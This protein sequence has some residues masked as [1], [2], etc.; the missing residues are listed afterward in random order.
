MRTGGSVKNLC[1]F[2]LLSLVAVTMPK[3]LCAQEM[4]PTQ[5]PSSNFNSIYLVL[6]DSYAAGS[7]I[8]SKGVPFWQLTDNDLS[9][10]Y[11]TITWDHL[12]LSGVGPESWPDVLPKL[13]SD[14]KKKG[15]CVGYILFQT[16]SNCFFRPNS[17]DC[18]DCCL[19]AT[20]SQAVSYSY[21]YKKYLST[22]IG[23]IY[24]A[25]P[26]VKLVV[27]TVPDPWNGSGKFASTSFFQEYQ[28]RLYELQPKYPQMRIADLFTV[29][30]GHPEYFKPTGDPNHPNDLGQKIIARSILEQFANWPYIG[31][32]H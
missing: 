23:E 31:S 29:M 17:P 8:D 14:Y 2:V 25:D 20:P 12:T 18:P 27:G 7:G 9:I 4:E 3:Y 1:F 16:G 19:G 21:A 30:Y 10:W 13:M 28:K 22:A 11:P 32:K 24:A 26:D 15:I 5:T 6:G